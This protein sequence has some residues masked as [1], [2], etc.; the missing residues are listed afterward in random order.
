MAAGTTAEPLRPYRYAGL[1]FEVRG[2]EEARK[3]EDEK[4][5]SYLNAQPVDD[6]SHSTH[7]VSAHGISI[8]G[9]LVPFH[10]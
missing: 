5:N 10:L 2:S 7:R 4:N 8:Y 6:L 9:P 1:A 3:Q